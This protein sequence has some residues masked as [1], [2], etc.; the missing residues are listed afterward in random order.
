MAPGDDDLGREPVLA[1]PR[2]SAGEP[3]DVSRRADPAAA[4]RE[5]LHRLRLPGEPAG[6]A[7]HHRPGRRAGS[8]AFAVRD[9]EPVRRGGGGCKPNRHSP[10]TERRAPVRALVSWSS[11]KD[12]AW[13]LHVL[14]ARGDVEVVGLLTTLS[15]AYDRVAT[16]AV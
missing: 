8:S 9:R 14:R 3:D 16:H 7:G 6:C 5:A 11:G 13:T 1:L 2:W 4:R 10:L 12:S 15:E